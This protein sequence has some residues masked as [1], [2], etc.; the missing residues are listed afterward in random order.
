MREC[1]CRKCDK[2]F[3]ESDSNPAV[4]YSMPA[5]I[6][7]E[8]DRWDKTPSGGYVQMPSGEYKRKP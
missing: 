2:K 6:C 7:S 3:Y 5:T 1:T 4:H 8:C